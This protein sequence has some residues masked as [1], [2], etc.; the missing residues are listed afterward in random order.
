MKSYLRFLWRNRLYSTINL[1]GLT[2]ALALS[3]IIFSYAAAQVRISKDIDGWQDIYAVCRN[4]STAMCYGMAGALMNA[5]PEAAAVTKF[6]SPDNGTPAEYGGEK[7]STD[8]MFADSSFFRMFNV[9]FKEGN[10][11]QGLGNSG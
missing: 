1:V 10:A 7:Y 6:S 3:I 8:M 11:D 4:N 5:M 9:G 2:V